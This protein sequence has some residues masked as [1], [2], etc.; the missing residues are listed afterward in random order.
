MSTFPTGKVS[1]GAKTPRSKELKA[2][3]M[4]CCLG[5]VNDQAHRIVT[6]TLNYLCWCTFRRARNGRM[7]PLT[8]EQDN[9]RRNN[10][11]QDTDTRA[12]L[13]MIK[14]C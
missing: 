11:H 2:G 7:A 5:G 14:T 13:N 9:G 8:S 1:Y 12:Q 4:I 3:A 10:A 6:D